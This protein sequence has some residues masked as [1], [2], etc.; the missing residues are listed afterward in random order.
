[1]NKLSLLVGLVLL[2]S[3]VSSTQVCQIYDNFSS[4]VL[5]TSKWEIR[6]DYEGQPFTDEYWVD[7]G[8]KNFHTQQNTIEDKRVY[9]VSKHN[10]TTG[11]VLEYD[12]NVISKEGNYM[13]MDLLTGDQ[14][15]RI[16]I[17]G[18]IGGVQG[19]DELGISHIKIEFQE[20]N[21]HLERT[22]PSNVTLIDNLPLTNANGSYELYIGSVFTNPAHIDYD[23]FKLCAEIPEP[24][25]EERIIALEQ[26]VTEL[27][28]KVTLLETLLNKMK[29]W[30]WFMPYP[31]QKNILCSSLKETGKKNITEWNIACEMK[32]FKKRDVCVCR[33]V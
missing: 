8:L 2:I 6:Q 24:S 19:Y 10:F 21:L 25:L 27:E 11:D 7:S 22:S 17:M 12:F 29:H 3:F 26:K 18:Y 1:M 28:N 14:Y 20:N 23:N 33:K 15:I 30:F 5:D 32:D 16:G 4:G 31:I 9:L 13:Q